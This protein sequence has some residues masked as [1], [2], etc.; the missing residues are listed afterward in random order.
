MHL[1]AGLFLQQ[2]THP[3]LEQDVGL[4]AVAR[5]QTWYQV[6]GPGF[7]LKLV[8]LTTDVLAVWPTPK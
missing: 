3:L 1:N 7:G 2:Q 5:T 6:G 8:N 4:L